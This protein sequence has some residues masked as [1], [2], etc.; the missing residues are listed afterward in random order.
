M[1]AGA[2]RYMMNYVWVGMI[3]LSVVVGICRGDYSALAGSVMNGAAQA[4]E[5]L[6][7]VLGIICFWSGI[8][9]IAKESGLNDKLAKI[10]SP[11]LR[12]L[13]RNIPRDSEAMKYMSLNISANLLGLGNAAT[14]FG[15][16]AMQ[17]LKKLSDKGETASDSM[18]LFVVMN[19]ASLQLIPTTLAA[20]RSTYGSKS[21]FDILPAV[22]VTSIMAL[23]VGLTVAKLLCFK[24]K[25]PVE[26]HKREGDFLWSS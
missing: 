11:V 13:F 18:V 20:Y 12:L 24:G 15:I 10:F 26:K 21:P 6:V 16:A 7:S 3:V 4:V 17:E 25:N 5:L 14:P 2:Q 22:W 9:E 19:T 1:S 8:M 23:A